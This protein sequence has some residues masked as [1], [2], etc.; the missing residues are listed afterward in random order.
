M[1]VLWYTTLLNVFMPYDVER[2]FN[3]YKN[4]FRSN[5]NKKYSFKNL[6][7]HVILICNTFE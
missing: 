1:Y 3:K 7:H 5:N 2:N 6:K 4:I